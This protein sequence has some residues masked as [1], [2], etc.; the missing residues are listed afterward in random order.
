M[1]E[2]RVDHGTVCLVPIWRKS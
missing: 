2:F 1:I